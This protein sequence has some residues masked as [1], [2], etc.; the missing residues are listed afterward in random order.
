M[1]RLASETLGAREKRLYEH[2]ASWRRG[3]VYSFHLL[4]CSWSSYWNVNVLSTHTCP[5]AEDQRRARSTCQFHENRMTTTR[6]PNQMIY[7][8][9]IAVGRSANWT[10]VT[11][12]V[13]HNATIATIQLLAV[14]P[15][16]KARHATFGRIP[17]LMS[18]LVLRYRRKP[19]RKN[20]RR[21]VERWKIVLD[22]EK[23]WLFIRTINQTRTFSWSS[24]G[25]LPL[26]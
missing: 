24:A 21:H 17:E 6:K 4:N 8:I 20:C 14:N 25:I 18:V 11:E 19:K 22:F 2:Y 23:F 3:Q 1:L 10:L 15:A 16:K 9:R 13:R 26:Q 5:W 7:A 12:L